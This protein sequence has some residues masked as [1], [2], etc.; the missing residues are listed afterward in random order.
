MAVIEELKNLESMR[1]MI[2]LPLKGRSVGKS[3]VMAF[4]YHRPHWK[5]DPKTYLDWEFKVDQLFETNSY[6]V[7]T[8]DDQLE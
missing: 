4:K 5:S 8:R 2:E 1:L 7:Q 3:S 6:I